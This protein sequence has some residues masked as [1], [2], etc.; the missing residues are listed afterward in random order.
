MDGSL[1]VLDVRR[2]EGGR[3]SEVVLHVWGNAVAAKGMLGELNPLGD[4]PCRSLADNGARVPK[5]LPSAELEG[6]LTGLIVAMPPE[7]VGGA[8]VGDDVEEAQELAEVRAVL[9]RILLGCASRSAPF[10][11]T[12]AR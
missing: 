8:A 6:F 3:E 9:S 11:L 10:R 7:S 1:R 5:I 12:S 4:G 2:R